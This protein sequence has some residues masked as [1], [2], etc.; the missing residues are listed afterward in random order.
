MRIFISHQASDSGVSRLIAQYL[1]ESHG[2]DSYLDVIDV[3]LSHS[4]E[5]LALH[6]Q[7]ELGKCT[8]L[9]AVVSQATQSSWWVP[10][11]IGIATE[12]DQPLATYAA[13]KAKLPEYL[14]RWPY[15]RSTDDL[16]IY[17]NTSRETEQN[18]IS[19]R[20]M[21]NESVARMRSTREF[22]QILRSRLGQ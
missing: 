16:D 3:H 22:F 20:A 10:W 21:L 2:I 18:F 15:L 17:A 12:K 13:G 19:R 14:Q 8:Q 5:D 6:I 1:K 7:S 9:L 11:E 4:G